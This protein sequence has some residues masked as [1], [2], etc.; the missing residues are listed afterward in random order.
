MLQVGA[1]EEEEE[2][3]RQRR[4]TMTPD[5]HMRLRRVGR[6]EFPAVHCRWEHSSSKKVPVQD[7]LCGET[8]AL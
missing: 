1:I 4:K 5:W 6:H 2:E 8:T 7:S 3:E